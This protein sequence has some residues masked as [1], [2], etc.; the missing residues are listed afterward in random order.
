VSFL[1]TSRALWDG[2]ARRDP[3][4]AILSDPSKRNG[5][6]DLGR[7]FQTGVGE[8]ALRLYQAR[9]HGA[10][11]PKGAALDFGCG[12]GRLSQAL[13]PHFERVVGVD[14]S[15]EMVALA[16]QLNQHPETVSYVANTAPDLRIF[17]DAHFA[18]I[19]S[20]IVLQHIR[21]DIALGY[22]REFLRILAPGGLL[23]FQLPSHQRGEGDL[24]PPPAVAAMPDEAYAAGLRIREAPGHVAP[25]GHVTVG[26]EITN[27]SPFEWSRDAFG[28]IRAGNHWLDATG[29]MI[30]RDDGRE[31]LP[32]TLPSGDTTVVSI[33]MTAPSEAG[34]YLCEIDLAHEGVTWFADKG[35]PVVRIAVTAGDTQSPSGAARVASP[36]VPPP[37]VSAAGPDTLDA[38]ATPTVGNPDAEDPGD[39]P[40]YGVP[41][42]EVRAL[43]V[44]GGGALF[45]LEDDR[46]C[47]DDWVSY[48]YYVR[49]S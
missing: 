22:L 18:A 7:F 21:P 2:H 8:I 14:V 39:F 42:T 16:Q 38:T 35:S 4:W 9:A 43:L 3:L 15:P 44:K 28:V 46:S 32:E 19:I 10:V 49:R 17:P 30:V 36:V 29:A 6:W 40:M 45:H 41:A 11:I 33:T 24:S 47:G 48:R 37:M 34:D 31:A 5:K 1:E 20:N 25:G 27:T 26:V 23:I 13:A 12:V